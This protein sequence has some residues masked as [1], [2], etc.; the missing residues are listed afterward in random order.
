[1]EAIREVL[2]RRFGGQPVQVAWIGGSANWAEG[3]SGGKWSPDMGGFYH[4][5]TRPMAAIGWQT[6]RSLVLEGITPG[7]CACE[8]I[9]ASSNLAGLPVPEA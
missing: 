1:M 3:L 4:A 8:T 2:R 9:V 7:A 6:V 5:C